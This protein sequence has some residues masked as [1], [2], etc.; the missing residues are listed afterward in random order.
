MDLFRMQ[1]K[2]KRFS[3]NFICAL[4]WCFQPEC[5]LHNMHFQ[6]SSEELKKIVLSKQTWRND[7]QVGSQIDVL[8]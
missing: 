6:F 7:I 5:Y 4:T 8:V 3:D 1:S 2:H